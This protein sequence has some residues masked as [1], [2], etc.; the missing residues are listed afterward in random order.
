MQPGHRRITCAQIVLVSRAHPRF[1]S[2]VSRQS[3]IPPAFTD[4]P[5]RTIRLPAAADDYARL[6]LTEA[7]AQ[8]VQVRSVGTLL[9]FAR[10][11]LPTGTA[12]L[13]ADRVLLRRPERVGW[14]RRVDSEPISSR[15]GV[16]GPVEPRMI[17]EDLDTRSDDE[18]HDEQIE[19]VLPSHPGGQA[20]RR[21]GSVRQGGPGV[22]HDEPLY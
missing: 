6:G 7:T 21:I 19:E 20:C 16:P 22:A 4:R 2:A 12:T 9:H 3:P 17:G 5:S 8:Q 14:H 13:Q 15:G 10:S 1:A 18:D 11:S